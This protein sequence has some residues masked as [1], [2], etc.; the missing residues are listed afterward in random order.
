MIWEQIDS[1]RQRARHE[2][3]SRQIKFNI[4]PTRY[5]I[6]LEWNKLFLDFLER[7]V[8]YIHVPPTKVK[9][10]NSKGIEIKY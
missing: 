6:R 5:H 2:P 8:V 1:G 3:L 10:L 4:E 7:N 9:N